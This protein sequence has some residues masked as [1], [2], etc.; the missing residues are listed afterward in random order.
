[1]RLESVTAEIRPRSDWEAVDLGLAMVR[2]DFW[3]C[4]GSWWLAMLPVTGILL[5]LLWDRP[6]LLLAFFWWLKPAGARLV[7]FQISRRLFGEKPAWRAVW[8]ELPRAYCRRFFYRFI[9]AR[10]SPWMPVT[11]AVED[12][13]GLR[14][15]DYQQRARQLSR[16]GD[17]AVMWSYVSA[18]LAAVWFGFA[19]FGFA[20]MALPE[21]QEAPWR[22]AMETWRA[23]DPGD[24]PLLFARTSVVCVMLAMSLADTFLTGAGFGIY[25]NNRT[26]IEGWDV[27]LA[28]RRLGQRLSS[29]ALLVVMAVFMTLAGT[30]S[31]RAEESW[32]AAEVIQEVKAADDFEVHSRKIRVPNPTTA[33][34]PTSLI[35]LIGTI[36]GYSAA[37]V[38]IGLI[39]WALWRH[40]H[41]FAIR[42][43]LKL[44]LPEPKARVVM[45]MEVTPESLPS[46]V[47]VTAWRWWQEGRRQ[48][49]LALL[50]RGAISR[51][52]E[53]AKVEIRESDTE[54]DC[55][56]RVEAAGAPA[57]PGY[58]RSLT[59]AWIGL[60]YADLAPA[61]AEVEALCAQ[62]PFAGRGRG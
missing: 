15:K 19:I 58:F 2:R 35:A 51:A 1:M 17:G 36:L 42:R 44:A 5:Y 8:R 11:L 61:D 38:V 40:R 31:V 9:V 49:A 43:R 13:E 7:L 62:W 57:H 16:R 56:Q 26:W 4:L 27:E 24:I 50:Y 10:F 14:G 55:L 21:G 18:D 60:A 32:E 3:R 59:G 33:S 29:A 12:L 34:A 37:A 23:S 45:G 22:I 54:G 48:E 6:L 53:T 25:V 47:P 41:A 20:S 46:D 52:I 30:G 28:F 39:G